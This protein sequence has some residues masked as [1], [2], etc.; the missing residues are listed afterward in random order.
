MIGVVNDYAQP[1]ALLA[2]VT[3]GLAWVVALAL[4]VRH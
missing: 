3:V 1:L 4:A 2:L